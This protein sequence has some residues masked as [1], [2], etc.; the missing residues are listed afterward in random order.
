MK[1]SVPVTRRSVQSFLNQI[2]NHP[3]CARSTFLNENILLINFYMFWK[4]KS[5][6]PFFKESFSA[7]RSKPDNGTSTSRE[8]EEYTCRV[9]MRGIK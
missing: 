9:V 5:H 3:I 6:P 2:F 7:A 4:I 1:T 8:V